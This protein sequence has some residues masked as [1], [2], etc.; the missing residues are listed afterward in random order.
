MFLFNDIMVDIETLSTK[1]NASI[2]EIA[3]VPF[4][5]RNCIISDNTFNIKIKP[6]EWTKNERD[7]DGDTLLWWMKQ[8]KELIEPYY[9]KDIYTLKDALIHF[10]YFIINHININKINENDLRIW[11]NGSVFDISILNDAFD[12]C[13]I[14]KPWKYWQ[15]SD[16][17][18]IVDLCPSIKENTKFEGH[19]HSA[20]DDCIHQIHYLINTFKLIKIEKL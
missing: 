5:K 2:I 18:T 10:Q 16:V 8:D 19:K 13:N 17:R 15:I 6:S 9:N 11:G 14:N 7:V 12:Y 3:A 20:L 4:D 1:N